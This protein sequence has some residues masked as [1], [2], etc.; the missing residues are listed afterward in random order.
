VFR[1]AAR[2]VRVVGGLLLIVVAVTAGFFELHRVR[3]QADRDFALCGGVPQAHGCVSKLR[4]VSVSWTESSNNG[5]RREYEVVVQTRPNVTV[6]LGGLS[7]ADVAPFDGLQATEIRYRQGR[8][9]AFVAPNGTALEFPFAFSMH[10]LVVLGS[11]IVAGLLGA[12]SVAWGFTRVNRT[13]RA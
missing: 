12:G 10:L 1:R 8:L 9:V 3:Q 13:P 6:S 7:K 5:F 4:P 11:V 2:E